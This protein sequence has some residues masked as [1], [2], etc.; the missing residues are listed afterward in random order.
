[1]RWRHGY[2]LVTVLLGQV[3][4][5]GAILRVCGFGIVCQGQSEGVRLLRGLRLW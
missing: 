5:V 2:I 3:Y 1:M 4:E